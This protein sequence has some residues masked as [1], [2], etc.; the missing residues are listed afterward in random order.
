MYPSWL[1]EYDSQA[2]GPPRFLADLSPR[3]VLKHPG[4][5]CRCKRR[6]LHGMCGLH[7]FG[8]AGRSHGIDEAESGSF[9]LLRL[10]DLVAGAPTAL[11]SDTVARVPLHSQPTITM[12]SS[13][14][15]TR[16][17]RLGLA[18]KKGLSLPEFLAQY[19]SED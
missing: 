19:S 5:P 15:L 9:A 7:H 3:A 1:S 10:M 17:A 12:I 2:E 8:Q 11:L 13:F 6:L 18:H 14:Q 16:S 4:E